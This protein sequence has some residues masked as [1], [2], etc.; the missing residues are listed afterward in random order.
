MALERIDVRKE[1]LKIAKLM[2]E[3][4]TGADSKRIM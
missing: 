3:Q 2:K 1:T 4:I